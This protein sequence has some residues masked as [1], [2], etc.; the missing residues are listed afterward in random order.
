MTHCEQCR[1]RLLDH[2]YGLL[3]GSDLH[4]TREHLSHCSACQAALQAVQ[5]EQLLMASAARAITEIPEFTLP[6][7]EPA[8]LPLTTPAADA[9]G[10]PVG[11]GSPK[12]PLWRRAWVGWTIAAGLLIAVSAVVSSYRHTVQSYEGVLA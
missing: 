7:N 11:P 6:A 9:P 12:R 5:A 4:E 10:S 1:D 3:E 8:V 2:V